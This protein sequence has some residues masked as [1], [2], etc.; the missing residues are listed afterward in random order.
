MTLMTSLLLKVDIEKDAEHEFNLTCNNLQ[1]EIDERL[2]TYAQLLRSGAAFFSHSNVITKDEWRNFYENQIIGQNIPEIQSIGY[3]MIIPPDQLTLH[4]KEIQRKGFPQYSVKPTGKRK[5]Y[6]SIVYMEPLSGRNLQALGY[7]MFSEPVHR[8]AMETARDRDIVAYCKGITPTRETMGIHGNVMYMPVYEKGMPHK[9]TEERRHAIKGWVFSSYQ[10]NDLMTGIFD[11]FESSIEHRIHLKIFDNSSYN[12]DALLYDNGKT[13]DKHTLSSSIFSLKTSVS[14]NNC[15]WHL[16]FTQHDSHTS[17]LEYSKMWFTAAGVTG[18]SI[19]LLVIYLLLINT[20]IRAYKLAEEL[21]R[22]LRESE[23]KHSSMIFNISDV[24]CI[25]DANGIFKYISPNIEKWFGWQ[26][27]N[28]TGTDAWLTIHPDDL[29]SLQKE[30]FSLL[31]KDN[32]TKTV[33]C[34]LKCKDGNYKPVR[35]TGVNLINNPVINGVL[36]NYHDITERR[37]AE[38]TSTALALRNQILLQTASDGIHIL[39]GNGNVAEV[40]PVF[41][42]MLGYSREELLKLNVADWDV[43]FPADELIPRIKK[44]LESFSED[45][46][47]SLSRMIATR[48]RRKDGSFY[49]AEINYSAITLENRQYLYSS[50]RDITERIQSAEALRLRESYLSTII[51]NQPGMLWLK[52]LNGRYL[53]VNSKFSDFYG[54]PTPD[55]LIGKT[56]YTIS[57]WELAEKCYAEDIRVIEK[58]KIIVTEERISDNDGIKWR[59]TFKAPIIGGQGIVMG[60]MG[61]SVDITERKQAEEILKKSIQR[62]ELAMNTADMAW[63][64]MELPSGSITF[65]KRKAEMLGFPPERFKYYKDFTDLVH[66]DDYERIMEIMRRHIQGTLNRYETEYRILTKDNKYKWFYDIGSVVEGDSKEMPVKITGLVLDITDRKTTELELLK[67][68]EKLRISKIL[69]EENLIQEH[70]LVEKLTSTQKTLEK[71]NS[72]KDKLFSIIAHD[73]KSPFQG[74]LGVAK[75]M[76]EDIN[77]FS[78]DE[79]SE[80]SQMMYDTTKNLFTLLN[81][82]LEWA[83][84]QR[85]I[86]SFEPVEL[87]LSEIVSWNID[88]ISKRGE[89]KGIELINETDQYRTVHADEAMLNS[90]LRNLL[91][92]AVKFTKHGGKVIVRAT[93]AENNMMEISVTDSGIGIPEYLFE[94]LFKMDEKTGRKGTDDEP[95]TGLGLLLCKEFVEKHGGKIRAESKKDKGT[96]FYFTIPATKQSYPAV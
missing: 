71:I 14:L 73:L 18:I 75:S 16:L 85:G 51:E 25:L 78:Q 41:C 92:N 22:D 3:A 34:R 54:F 76:A 69:I 36:L 10:I 19:L 5:I 23:I 86:I 67:L 35:L 20:N 94:K 62:L 1:Y 28:L 39:D 29:D 59:E 12:P 64:E 65:G 38:E 89:Q 96:T 27:Q 11:H 15:Q 81:N 49:F 45:S 31:E 87:V 74:L 83:R 44:L 47:D 55:P 95:S 30:F 84:M 24:V 42:R 9:T 17:N 79:L 63:W 13:L 33:E 21:T 72:E 46:S 66:P 52:D 80:V 53:V 91:S 26:S 6:T 32:S 68:N 70:S 48:H 56:D 82:L 43:G 7:D 50:T 4:E 88:L 58:K 93:E 2:H 77:S 8:E 61:Y 57:S 40:N 60:T 37:Q 90:V